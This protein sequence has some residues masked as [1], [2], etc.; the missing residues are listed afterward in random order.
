MFLKNLSLLNYKSFKQL[1]IEFSPKINCFTGLNGMGKTNLLDS[2]YYL[3]F[4]KSF[5]NSVDSQ[6]INYT[7]NFFIIEGHFEKNGS[8]EKIYCGVKRN[9]KKKIKRNG[10]DYER[11]VDHIGHFPAVMISPY[12]SALILE[13][14]EERRRFLNEVIS[15]FDPVYMDSL[16]K[17][18]RALEQRN[19]LLRQFAESNTENTELLEIWNLQLQ[20][21]GQVIYDKRKN[22]MTNFCP[23]FQEYYRIISSEAENVTLEYESQL[24]NS[25]I[26][27]LL[28]NSLKKD[29]ALEYTTVGI[30]KDD[31]A[32]KIENYPIKKSGSQGQ[33]K[34]FLLALK[35]AEFEFISQTNGFHPILLLDDIFDKL[36]LQRMDNIIGLLAK[37]NFGQIFITDTDK[38]HLSRILEKKLS[39]YKMFT[40]TNGDCTENK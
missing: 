26:D 28:K 36:D 39:D 21:Y 8:E 3:S 22:F 19:A 10:K 9:T 40:V 14:S 17:Y 23:I 11:L 35:F 33:Q 4:T 16:I 13:G 7:E 12:D 18:N 15:L 37:D 31:L 32:F 27:Q 20:K 34:S 5:F 38:S 24:H 30:H 6:N 1:N 29:L 2:I 25:P